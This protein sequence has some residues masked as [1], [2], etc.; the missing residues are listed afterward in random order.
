MRKK[1]RRIPRA[2]LLLFR[3]YLVAGIIAIIPIWVTWLLIEFLFR[4]LS[5]RGAPVVHELALQIAPHAPGMARWL[6]QPWFQSLLAVTLMIAG[7]ASL[8]W[9]TTRVA[10]QRLLT[11][12]DSLVERIPVVK[13]VYGG[14]KQLLNSLQARPDG[15]QRVVLIDFPSSEMKTVG[16]VTRTFVDADTGRKLAAVY[17]PTTPNPTSGY[18]EIVPVERITSTSWTVDEAMNFIISGGTVAPAVMNFD[19]SVPAASSEQVPS[20]QVHDADDVL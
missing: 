20:S 18:L 2:I 5:S 19:R 13:M 14:V 1:L 6:E 17:V 10:G 8:G 11:W 9:L 12:F 3:T 15:V 4:L 16:L 7:L